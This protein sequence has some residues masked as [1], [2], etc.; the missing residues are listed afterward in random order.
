MTEEERR[1]GQERGCECQ[2]ALAA[3]ETGKKHRLQESHGE[4]AV[5]DRPFA[6][7]LSSCVRHPQLSP[8]HISNALSYVR[9][10]STH[11]TAAVS[12]AEA[13]VESE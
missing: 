3:R 5:N 9:K 6:A 12:T 7:S 10:R 13:M 8:A 2:A 4:H 11:A 1:L